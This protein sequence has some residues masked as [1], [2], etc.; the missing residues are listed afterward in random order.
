MP[1]KASPPHKRWQRR[2]HEHTFSFSFWIN[3]RPHFKLQSIAFHSVLPPALFA[4]PLS[5]LFIDKSGDILWPNT[6]L[7][8]LCK[9]HKRIH[10][11]WYSLACLRDSSCDKNT[12]A[13]VCTPPPT[14][15]PSP[16]QSTLKRKGSRSIRPGGVIDSS[17]QLMVGAFCV[18]VAV[19]GR[20]SGVRWSRFRIL[21][22]VQFSVP[23]VHSVR[24]WP[25][26]SMFHITFFL[27]ISVQNMARRKTD[28][29]QAK[30]IQTNRRTGRIHNTLWQTKSNV[31]VDACAHSA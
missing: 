18:T 5:P 29:L 22:T 1:L 20:R 6:L 9:W 26:V 19:G 17:G 31:C 25:Y 15:D 3:K 28:R 30:V 12:L 16:L 2:T 8:L 24:R 10:D 21:L 13:S 27:L 23:L 14:T 11:V 7:A 4:L